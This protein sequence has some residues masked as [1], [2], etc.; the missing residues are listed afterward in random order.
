MA[1][2]LSQLIGGIV[3]AFVAVGMYHGATTPLGPTTYSWTAAL[4]GE[5]IFTFVL[6]LVVLCV[7][8]TKTSMK[9]LYGLA[10]GSCV[11]AGGL[12]LG[13]ISGGSLNPAVSVG[14]SASNL[15]NGGLF[16]NC[17]LYSVVECVGAAAA[18]SVFYVTHPEEYSKSLLPLK[19]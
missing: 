1:Y 9:H 10:I 12:A 17:L 3:A 5:V 6:C 4:L 7:A 14:I 16:Y 13:N 11:T 19:A 18:A 8:T 2:V 15:M